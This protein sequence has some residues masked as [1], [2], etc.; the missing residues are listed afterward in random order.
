MSQD[1]HHSLLNHWQLLIT[2]RKN[3]Q[4]WNVFSPWENKRGSSD[5]ELACCRGSVHLILSLWLLLKTTKTTHYTGCYIQTKLESFY[6]YK[7]YKNDV[8]TRN[9]EMVWTM[10]CEKLLFFWKIKSKAG[11]W[12]SPF[13]AAGV[14]RLSSESRITSLV[15]SWG[16]VVNLLCFSPEMRIGQVLIQQ[17]NISKPAEFLC[18]FSMCCTNSLFES[19]LK[20]ST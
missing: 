2:V 5:N 13:A 20:R 6:F 9:I 18:F 10:L 3:F 1:L 8:F 12:D 11:I 14:H 15:T 7:M 16:L 19:H 17:Q 4:C